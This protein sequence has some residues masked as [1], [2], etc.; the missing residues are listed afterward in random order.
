MWANDL[1]MYINEHAEGVAGI[2]R[3]KNAVWVDLANALLWLITAGFM[4]MHWVKNRHDRT[5][6]TGRA[7]V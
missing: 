4:A 3:M 2:T 7:K 6:F 5:R 1:Q